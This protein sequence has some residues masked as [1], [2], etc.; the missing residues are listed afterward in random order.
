[1]RTE[2]LRYCGRGVGFDDVILK[3]NPAELKVSN[4]YLVTTGFLICGQFIAY[5]LKEGK[6]VAVAAYVPN[7]MLTVYILTCLSD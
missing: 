2:A 1:M 7:F 3:G 6:V 5:Y 4:I